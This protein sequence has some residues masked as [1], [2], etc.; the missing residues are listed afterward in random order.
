MQ[1]KNNQLVKDIVNALELSV[2]G[3]GPVDYCLAC[4][5]AEIKKRHYTEE[6]AF[7]FRKVIIDEV[8]K[9]LKN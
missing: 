6:Q 5:N 7:D 9:A 3:V 2:R 8:E 4:I 1:K